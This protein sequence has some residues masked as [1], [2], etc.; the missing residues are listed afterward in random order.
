MLYAQFSNASIV[1]ANEVSNMA[2][3][4]DAIIA[5]YGAT[6]HTGHLVLAELRRR[7][8][9]V[10]AIGRCADKLDE[11][12]GIATR[13]AQTDDPDALDRAISGATVVINCAGPFLDTA[14]PVIESA[15]RMRV[16]YLDVTAEQ[17]SARDTFANYDHAARTGGVKMVPAAGFFGGLAE[18]LMKS[19]M[20]GWDK[21]D[22]V[23]IGVALDGWHPTA[24]TRATGERN[25]V[26]RVILSHGVLAEPETASLPDEWD[27]PAPF[28]LQDV[29]S[30]PL[31]EIIAIARDARIINARSFMNL[32]PLTELNDPLTPAPVAIDALGRSAQKFAVDVIAANGGKQRR[33]YAIGQ[34]IYAITASII[35]E[36][37]E[38][39]FVGGADST[40]NGALTLGELFEPC[41]FLDAVSV[42]YPGFETIFS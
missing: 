4:S 25:T 30:V 41:E 15:L 12:H 20:R 27:F 18:L 13:I 33:A 22:Q 37:A 14:Q 35:V 10:V 3:Q 31:S 23:R 40:S 32:L 8:L 17:Q 21:A 1:L 6:G 2:N 28:G 29:T 9:P 36:A 26:P 19:A 16:N 7:A 24:G 5:V 11:L 34:D 42:S 39:I 38:R